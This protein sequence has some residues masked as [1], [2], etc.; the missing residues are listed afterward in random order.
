MNVGDRVGIS[1]G[2]LDGDEDGLGVGEA[3]DV[4]V[5]VRVPDVVAAVL[6]VTE[7]F[8]PLTEV[9]TDVTVVPA[10]ILV[11]AD[12]VEPTAIELATV[13]RTMIDVSEL[14][15]IIP[16]VTTVW[17]VVYVGDRVGDAVGALLGE[18]EGLGVGNLREYVG[19]FVG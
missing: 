9:L 18:A 12:T 3:T 2:A 6:M 1:V 17:S 15:V 10:V 11:V 5:T 8:P 4:K 7:T 14:E 16:E 19:E 13:D